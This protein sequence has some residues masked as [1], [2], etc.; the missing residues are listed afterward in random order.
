MKLGPGVPSIPEK[1]DDFISMGH[2][3]LFPSVF[4]VSLPLGCYADLARRTKWIVHFGYINKTK[5]SFLDNY[6]QFRIPNKES[7]AVPDT[8]PIWVSALLEK[9]R[10]EMHRQI[11]AIPSTVVNAPVV[12][13][14]KRELTEL[15]DWRKKKTCWY[16]NQIKIWE[17]P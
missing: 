13:N 2:R 1:I 3:F 12:P 7:S 4:S 16:S 17:R 11:K 10:L 6:P 9:G 15:R 14:Y 5:S 8:I